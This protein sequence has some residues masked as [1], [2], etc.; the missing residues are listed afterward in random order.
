MTRTR[1]DPL[2]SVLLPLRDAAATIDAVMTS[3]LAQAGPPL[4]VVAVDD[5][6]VDDSPARLAGWARR[7][8]RVRVLA[9][10]GAGLVAALSMAEDAARGT[11]LA[12]MDADDRMRPERL[13][14]QVDRLRREPDLAL[15]AGRVHA[16]PDD[17]IGAGMR[18]Y[19]RWQDGCRTWR[20]IA[21]G[22]YVEAPFVHPTVTMRRDVV[23]R[24]GGY[25]DG[26]FPED[27]DLWLRIAAAGHRM[28]KLDA[29]VLDWR[30]HPGSLSRR[31]PR[32]RREAFD[33]LRARALAAE[34]RLRAGRDLVVWGAGRR[35]RKRVDV[36]LGHGFSVDAWIDIDPR[37]VGNRV[38]GAPVHAP[39]W[40]RDR[41]VGSRPFVLVYVASHGARDQVAAVLRRYGY[42]RG[43]DWLGVG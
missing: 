30:Q 35:T 31:D 17:A 26:D 32:Y 28:G 27:Y 36:L 7:D 33:R 37:K 42:R 5:G 6:S 19:L 39:A 16:F 23:R 40:L 38:S 13:R 34:P 22:I 21:D 25:R 10:G 11:F 15:V 14:R 2:V 41:P 9:S 43:R 1:P 4:E 24:L 8:R 3:V 29:L 12:R 20:D 18:E